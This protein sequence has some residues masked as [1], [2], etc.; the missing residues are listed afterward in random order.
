MFPTKY[1]LPVLFH[2]LLVTAV[3]LTGLV[4]TQNPLFVLGLFFMPE[5]PMLVP[6]P[7][8]V[9]KE[10]EEL[11]NGIGFLAEMADDVDDEF[12]DRKSA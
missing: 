5:Y 2:F 1:I 6:D 9:P 8:T 11:Q 4:M 3:V 7:T 12:E 10:K